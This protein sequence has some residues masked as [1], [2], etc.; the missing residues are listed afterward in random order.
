MKKTVLFLAMFVLCGSL[1]AQYYYADFEDGGTGSE[2]SWT[3]GNNADNPEL[4]FIDNPVSGGINTTP[5]VAQFTAR[6]GGQSWA[7]CYT[8]D[9][10]DFAFNAENST[11]KIMVNKPIISNVG[12][13]FEGSAAPMEIL[14]P[15]T[16]INQWEEITFDFSGAIGNSYNLMVIIPDF[17]DRPQDNVI[18]FDNIQL[19]SG[20]VNPDPEPTVAAPTPEV[21]SGDVISLF[22]NAYTDVT[23]DGWSTDWDQAF[24]EDIQ[25]EGN[26]TKLYTNLTYAAITFETETIDASGMDFFHMDI[27]TPNDTSAPAVFNVKLVDY[28]PDGVFDGGDDTESEVSFIET[29][30]DSE[31]WVSLD[32]PMI[33]FGGLASR[34]HLAMLIISGDPNTVYVDN[35]YFYTGGTGPAVPEIAAPTPT[36]LQENVVSLYSNA[37]TDVTVDTW[38]AEWDQAE[39]ADI[40]IEG[41]DTKLYTSLVFA[42]I[43]FTSQTIDATDMTHFSMDVWTPDSTADPAVFKVKL[44][45][46]G[47]DGAWGGGDDVEDELIFDENVMDTAA[48]VSLDIPL[49][50]FAGL[51]TTGHLAQMIISG[52]PNTVYID[53]IYFYNGDADVNENSFYSA[54]TLGENYPNPFNPTTT[55]SF[56]LEKAA[57]VTLSVYNVKGRLVETLIEGTLSPNSYNQV[58]NA[59]DSASGIYFYRLSVD[60]KEIDTKRMVLLK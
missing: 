12:I 42:G 37:Y 26:D 16:M 9:I 46:F 36:Q 4:E 56:S 31:T 27:W 34:E 29:T 13:K 30:M 43:E 58:W 47:A 40:Q 59:E 32:I 48:W 28:G 39:V 33:N 50:D 60:G 22:S 24:V 8:S 3:V 49:T 2:W 23:V 5:K 15:N 53:N 57:D 38:S 7:L 1:F 19:P 55:I 44:V 20:N 54:Y 51:T 25:I 10:Q 17:A 14:I 35:V 18:Y 6:A 45:D 11:V 41:N 52:D 21:P